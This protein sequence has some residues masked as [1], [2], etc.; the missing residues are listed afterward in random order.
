M[1][2]N[3]AIATKCLVSLKQEV[4]TIEE[5]Y[6]MPESN[7]H[8]DEEPGWRKFRILPKSSGIKLNNHAFREHLENG[9]VP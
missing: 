8:P 1:N 3:L 4:N 2:T 7:E 5:D 9:L 6:G